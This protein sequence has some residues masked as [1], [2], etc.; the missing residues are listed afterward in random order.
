[1]SEADLLVRARRAYEGGL[2]LRG[3]RTA[4]VV[5]PMALASWFVCRHPAV[6]LLA[7]TALVALVAFAVWRGQQHARGARL[8]LL[9]GV[10]PLLLPILAGVGGH[11]CDDSLCLFFP[12]ACLAGGLIGG[13]ALGFLAGG[14]GLGPLGVTTATVVAWLTGCLGCL[15]AGTLGVAILV[16]GLGF[17]LAP[18]LTL[19]RA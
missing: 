11:V 14:A 19:R 16:A 18:V 1:M 8:G 4:S 10:V 7:S 5:A 2:A 13:V 9:A 12:S 3:I 6:T 15:V 17:G